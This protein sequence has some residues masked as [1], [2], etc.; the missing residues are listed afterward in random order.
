MKPNIHGKSIIIG[1]A[2][3]LLTAG[4]LGAGLIHD[5]QAGRFQLSTNEGHAFVLDTVTGQVWEKFEPTGAGDGDADFGNPKLKP[6][7]AK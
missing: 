2:L 3:G 7:T 4:A 1:L 5:Q 6:D